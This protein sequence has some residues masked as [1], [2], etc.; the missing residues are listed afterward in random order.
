[1]ADAVEVRRVLVVRAVREI[2]AEDIDTRRD[3]R[4]DRRV[5]LARGTERGDNLRRALRAALLAVWTHRHQ[6][7]SPETAA[8]TA[9][10]CATSAAKSP[11][12]TRLRGAR[13]LPSPTDC[14][15][16]AR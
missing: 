13:S 3:H 7:P 2:H 9:R 6:P 5:I 11:A 8:T 12:L 10:A 14:A 4:R 1:M 16:A 15:P